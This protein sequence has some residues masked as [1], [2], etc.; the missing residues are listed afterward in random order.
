MGV[1]RW[2]L[3]AGAAA[4]SLSLLGAHG[5]ATQFGPVA[6]VLG[7]LLS[8]GTVGGAGAWLL[9]LTRAM[10]PAHPQWAVFFLTIAAT[11]VLLQV[12]PKPQR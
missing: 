6:G 5:L 7:C 4:A 11:L 1:H 12:L 10:W 2:S 8:G 3:I 9:G